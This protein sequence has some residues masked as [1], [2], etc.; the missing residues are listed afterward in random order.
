MNDLMMYKYKSTFKKKIMSDRET[1]TRNYIDIYVRINKR[2]Q[3]KTKDCNKSI[4]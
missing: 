3:K 1:T 4:G 2:Q